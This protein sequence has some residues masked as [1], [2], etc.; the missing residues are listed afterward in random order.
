MKKLILSLLVVLLFL[1]VGR[2]FS[3]EAFYPV[4]WITGRVEDAVGMLSGS[5]VIPASLTISLLMP[6]EPGYHLSRD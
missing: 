6:A 5:T 4:Y 3:E 2:S 1:G